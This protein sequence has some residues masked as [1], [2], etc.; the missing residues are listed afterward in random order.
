MRHTTRL[1]FFLSIFFMISYGFAQDI[2][3][4]EVYPQQAGNDNMEFIELYDG[5]VGN[6]PLD[7]YALVFY[8]SNGERSG[9][10]IS[11]DGYQTNANG[12]FV[13]GDSGVLNV[14]YVPGFGV[15]SDI[16]DINTGLALHAGDRGPDNSYSMIGSSNVVDAIYFGTDENEDTWPLRLMNCEEHKFR[17][18][19]NNLHGGRSPNLYSIQRSPNG[20][21]GARNSS[22]FMGYFP[23]PGEP[24][25]GWR[26]V[27]INEI[28]IHSG[29]PD[30]AKFIEIYDGGF[31]NTALDSFMVVLFNDSDVSYCVIDLLGRS[32]DDDGYF[33]IGSS[34]MTPAP[35][36]DLP[37]I[38]NGSDGRIGLYLGLYP[39]HFPDGTGWDDT[40]GG[41]ERDE[42]IWDYVSYVA[43]GIPETQSYQR[44]PN[45]A[46]ELTSLS[47]YNNAPPTPGSQNCP[48][49]ISGFVWLDRN[50]NGIQDVGESDIWHD[51]NSNVNYNIGELGTNG[52][53]VNLLNNTST[54]IA[55]MPT[56]G[57]GY[58]CFPDLPAAD[59]YIEVDLTTLG[60][61][62]FFSPQNQGD[63]DIDS[64]AN[65]AT[66]RTEV[67]A[68][69]GPTHIQD[70]YD[71]GF[72]QYA[73]VGDLVWDDNNGDG[74]RDGADAGHA[75][76]SVE[77]FHNS[78]SSAA[79]PVSTNSNGN[80][81]F[82]DLTPGEYYLHFTAPTGFSFTHP[83][84]YNDER[85]SE[86]YGNGDTRPFFLFSGQDDD[87]H[88]AGLNNNVFD[89]NDHS[90][91]T[92]ANGYY[93]IADITISTTRDYYV[94]F[95][96]PA[97]Y[98]FSPMNVGADTLDSDADPDPAANPGPDLGNSHV[99]TET[100]GMNDH[101]VDAG[102]YRKATIGNFVWNDMDVNGEYN[103]A[104][105]DTALAGVTVQL[106]QGGSPVE[107]PIV[108]DATG[109]YSFEVAP[110]TYQ[111]KFTPPAD[112][113]ITPVQGVGDNHN[114]ADAAD[115]LTAPMTVISGSVDTLIDAGMYKG[116]VVGDQVW[117]D[118]DGDGVQDSG[119]PGVGNVIVKIYSSVDDD[120]VA[121]DTTDA[122]GQYAFKGIPPGNYYLQFTLPVGYDAFTFPNLGGP[123]DDSDADSTGRTPAMA[124]TVGTVFD[125]LDAGL[126]RYGEIG[127]FVW[128]DLNANG[129]QETGEPGIDAVTVQLTGAGPDSLFGNGDDFSMVT[130]TT[131][132]TGHYIFQNL[133]P[134]AYHIEWLRP[135][136]AQYHYSVQSAGSL[137]LIDSDADAN[138][139]FYTTIVSG[140]IDTTLDAG[141][142]GLGE[143]G[144]IIWLDLDAD[145]LQETGEVGIT[146]VVTVGLYRIGTMDPLAATNT[147]NGG[148]GFQ[149]VVPGDYY[150]TF[151]VPNGYLLSPHNAG[152]DDTIDSD[153][154][155]ANMLNITRSDTFTIVS[156][157]IDPTI[158]GGIYQQTG[159]GDFV[160]DDLNANGVQDNGEPGI[161]S[162]EVRLIQTSNDSLI[163]STLT[164]VNGNFIIS[165]VTPG[166]YYL[167]FIRPATEYIFTYRDMVADS[168][169]SD[170]DSTG[171]TEDFTFLSGQDNLF[172]D[173]GFYRLA[174][175]G[176]FI[177]HDRDADGI[178]ESGE[179]GLGGINVTLYYAGL[180]H[181]FG[182]SDDADSTTNSLAGVYGFGD[183][184]PGRYYLDIDMGSYEISP[185]GQG[186]Q[187]SID[188]NLNP[189]TS[190][191]DIFT[192]ISHQNQNSM[193]AGGYL[194]T[195]LGDW[196]WLDMDGDG[197]QGVGELGLENVDIHLFG[198]GED[199][200]FGTSDDADESEDTNSSGF[201]S[202]DGMVP[203]LYYL[204]FDLPSSAYYVSPMNQAGDDIDSDV[205]PITMRTD[206]ITVYSDQPHN[207]MDMGLY[208]DG[209][210]GD[211][212]WE[213]Q[214]GDGVQDA[215]EPGLEGVYVHLFGAGLDDN[216]GTGDDIIRAD[217]TSSEGLYRFDN[218][219]PGRYRVEF[220]LLSGYEFSPQDQGDDQHDSD[221]DPATASTD[222]FTVVAGGSYPDWD[223]G[224]YRSGKVGDLVWED[225][226]GNGQQ[227]PGEPGIEGVTIE[228]ARSSDDSIVGSDQS[229]ANGFFEIGG[230][231]PGSYYLLLTPLAGYIP[232]EPD[233][234][235][236]DAIDNDVD[237]N[238]LESDIFDM[239]TNQIDTTR[240]A[241][242]YRPVSIGDR[243][244]NDTDPDGIQESGE[245]GLG[246][247]RVNLYGA[248]WNGIFH[249]DIDD[250]HLSATT[251]ASGSYLFN[252]LRPGEYYLEFVVSSGYTI[253]LQN[254]EDDG[255]LDSDADPETGIVDTL[256]FQSGTVD[257]SIDAGFF[258]FGSIGDL[259]YYDL[260][261][262]GV[263]NPSDRG[264]PNVTIDLHKDF[265]D[266]GIVDSGDPY[267]GSD[268]TQAAGSYLFE[269]LP[270][271]VYLVTI[272]DHNSV[273]PS[274][275][276]ILTDGS[277]P[278]RVSLSEGVD[279]LDADFGYQP[280]KEGSISGIIWN[281]YN[282]DCGSSDEYGIFQKMLQLYRD[283]DTVGVYQEGV[284]VYIA[285][286]LSD[287][288]GQY[289][290]QGLA[291]GDYFVRAILDESYS[292]TCS[293]NPRSVHLNL[294]QE[295]EH[296]NFGFQHLNTASIFG[297]V[298]NDANA[299]CQ[300]GVGEVGLV[301]VNVA[302]YKDSNQDGILDQTDEFL[303]L[304][305]TSNGNG[306]AGAYLFDALYAGY[307]LVQV[308]N[309]T[310]E[311]DGF[312]LVCETNPEPV[313]LLI[314]EERPDVHFYYQQRD[315]SINGV[316]WNDLDGNSFKDIDEPGIG[317]ISITLYRDINSNG[318]IDTGTD[319]M[320]GSLETDSGGN[321]DFTNLPAGDYLAWID[322]PPTG[323]VRT[324]DSN[325]LLISLIA[326]RI[327]T[328]A[329]FGYRQKDASINGV[330][331]NDLDGDS[332]KGGSELGMSGVTIS[333][334]QS[335]AE[336]AVDTTDVSGNYQFSDLFSGDH[337][338]TIT[339]QTNQLDG[340]AITTE[341]ETIPVSTTPG[342]Q[343]LGV[344]FGYQQ[345]DAV[346]SGRVWNDMDNNGTQDGDEIGIGNVTLSLYRGSN[347]TQD[348]ADTTNG[349]GYYQFSDLPFGNYRVQVTDDNG[350][351]TDFNLTNGLVNP[352]AT[353]V[354]A[355][356]HRIVNFGYRPENGV[357]R[358][359]VW[360]DLNGDGIRDPNESNLEGIQVD[361][362]LVGGAPVGSDNTASDGQYL[363]SNLAE[364]SYYLS[365][366]IS[367]PY[368]VSPRDQGS[369]DNMDSDAYENAQTPSF[370]LSAG[371]VI[372]SMDIGVYQT[373][374]V[375]DFVYEDMN[376]NGIQDPGEPGL[377]ELVV[378]LYKDNGD[379]IFI[380]ATLSQN[381]YYSFDG[382]D[383]GAYYLRFTPPNGYHTSPLDVGGDD[384]LD[385]DIDLGGQTETFV[386]ESGEV[387]AD[388]DAGM[389]RHSRINGW[390]W[391]DLNGD[392]LQDANE[393]GMENLQVRLFRMDDNSV[394][395]TTYSDATGVYRFLD[396]PPA[397]YYLTI[398]DV[399]NYHFT[400]QGA[401]DP[402]IDSDVNT[403]GVSE[404][405]MLLSDQNRQDIDAG[406]Y[407]YA[408]LGDFVWEDMNENG[409]QDGGEDEMPNV[410]VN[411]YRDGE[412]SPIQSAVT[413]GDGEYIFDNLIPGQFY[414]EILPPNGYSFTQKD[415]G[416]DDNIDSDASVNG[417][418]SPFP[419]N[420]GVTDMSWD[421]GMITGTSVGDLVWEDL[422]VN[423][424]QDPGE[425]GISGVMVHLYETPTTYLESDTTDSQGLYGFTSLSD[426]I[427]YLI[428]TQPDDYSFTMRD[429]GTDDTVDSDVDMT[430]RTNDFSLAPGQ[431]NSDIDAGFYQQATIGDFV[432]ED[433]NG[434]G[435]Q[436]ENE[437]DRG[438][439]NIKATLYPAQG[440][441]SLIT[442]TDTRG[443]YRF[444]DVNPGDYRL[445][446]ALLNTAS[447]DRFTMSGQGSDMNVD[448]DPDA[449]GLTSIFSLASGDS[450][451]S[452][453]AGLYR[454]A[455]VQGIVWLDEN[456]DGI[457]NPIEQERPNVSIKLLDHNGQ[458]I[459]STS[460]TGS[461]SFSDLSPAGY[462][463]QAMEVPGLSFSPSGA[464][465]K[466]DTLTGIVP[467]FELTSGQ[468]AQGFH[469]GF[470]PDED[471]DRIVDSQDNC[472]SDP[473]NDQA[474]A[475]GD[476]V[477]DVCDNCPNNINND[478]I[479]DDNDS[480]GDACDACL[481]FDDSVDGDN[482]QIPDGCDELPPFSGVLASTAI[483]PWH[484]DLTWGYN[485]NN[486]MGFIIERSLNPDDFSDAHS[487]QISANAFTYRDTVEPSTQYCYRVFAFNIA[488]NP[489]TYSNV[490]CATTPPTPIV[491]SEVTETVNLPIAATIQ[492]SAWGDMD[493]DGY[494]DLF[495]VSAENGNSLRLF[496]NQQGAGFA[497]VSDRLP[498]DIAGSCALWGDYDNDLDL[499][500]FIGS[501]THTSRIYENDGNGFFTETGDRSDFVD[502]VQSAAWADFDRDGDIDLYVGRRSGQ[503]NQLYRNDLGNL[504]PIQAGM[505]DSTGSSQSCVWGDFD[506]D[507]DPDLFVA[508]N[509]QP[510][511]LYVNMDGVFQDQAREIGVDDENN[512]T[513]GAAYADFDNDG[514][515][516]IF[517]ANNGQPNRLYVNTDGLFQDQASNLGVASANIA[518]QCPGWGD[519]DNDMDLDLFV[520][521]LNNE[522]D[523][524]FINQGT[525]FIDLAEDV[526]IDDISGTSSAAWAD[527]D[528][529]GFIDL[530]VGNLSSNRLYQNSGNQSG[531]LGLRLLGDGANG[532]AIGA[533][534]RLVADG[535]VQTREVSGGSGHHS[536]NSLTLM[537][538]LHSAPTVDSL[539]IYFRGPVEDVVV[540]T[541]I[542]ANQTLEISQPDLTPPAAIDDLQEISTNMNL[543]IIQWTA[544]GDNG[545]WGIA[546][547]YD[548]RWSLDPILD[549]NGDQTHWEEAHT[550][551]GEPAPLS[552]RVSQSDTLTG[553]PL[554]ETVYVAIRTIDEAG[555]SSLSNM[556]R[557]E[558][559]QQI[560]GTVYD[561]QDTP[562]PGI[563]I[564]AWDVFPDGSVISTS[565]T[566]SE[567]N[568][569]LT[570]LT[571][572]HVYQIRAHSQAPYDHYPAILQGITSPSYDVRI[573]LSA[574]PS[575]M[576]TDYFA[577]FNCQGGTTLNDYPVLDGDVIVAVDGQGTV[578]GRAFLV[579]TGG[580]QMFVYGDIPGTTDK[581]GAI[582]G[583]TLTFRV[584]D[585]L[586]D[587]ISGDP[588][589]HSQTVTELC[590]AAPGQ[591]IQ[592]TVPLN[593]CENGSGWNLISWNVNPLNDSTSDVFANILDKV[594][595]VLGYDNGALSFRPDLP[596]QFN[597]LQTVD[598]YHGYWVKVT[599]SCALSVIGAPVDPAT[600]LPLRIGWNF[601]SYTPT[602]PSSVT[603][604]LE[605][606]IDN[607]QIAISY[608]GFD[609]Q[610]PARIF[611]PLLPPSFSNFQVI[612]PTMGLWVRMTAPDTLVYPQPIPF[613]AA[614]SQLSASI[615]SSTELENLGERG[616]A[617]TNQWIMIYSRDAQI[618]DD[619]LP[620]GTLITA[621][622][623]QGQVCGATLVKKAGQ[624]GLMAIYG[625]DPGTTEP[626]NVVPGES[627]LLRFTHHELGFDLVMEE[628][629]IWTQFGDIQEAQVR[630]SPD[631]TDAVPNEFNLSQNSPNPF[632][633]E[634]FISFDLPT[635]AKTTLKVYN[636]TGQLVRTLIKDQAYE[637]GYYS[638]IWDGRNDRGSQASSGVYFYQ[639][640]AKGQDGKR[641]EATRRM[642]L[643]R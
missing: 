117:E 509:G 175:V 272:T 8:F 501:D 197:V 90:V 554:H 1:F 607:M 304:I 17:N 128:D 317:Q 395:G 375:G 150:L 229:D 386:L 532:S 243:V 40:G 516:D 290:F 451:S 506:N 571:E 405:F 496:H 422:N 191:T 593:R 624:F 518:S 592:V 198:A 596:P 91:Y 170:A 57:G 248:G 102:M 88:D 161:N 285:N 195:S 577:R 93:S 252:D 69:T 27:R 514:D 371:Q 37:N 12:Y 437:L 547:H 559:P 268:T 393:S 493:N 148:Y 487:I 154:N 156:N 588:I 76:V 61:D 263:Q 495:L 472:P 434:N 86:A 149:N 210:V 343:L 237:S 392:G 265:N 447:A 542:E 241:G 608:D 50:A 319:L 280:L 235:N 459:D 346:I 330:V 83:Y 485:S 245:P 133:I 62:Y 326:G 9:N 448:S 100:A 625:D 530:H 336:I 383:P 389:F 512:N 328:G 443:M 313:R 545:N 209:F 388:I 98:H 199:Q 590:L 348:D 274:S 454:Y 309:I 42:F 438:I 440:G 28:D 139:I 334:Y 19:T 121:V 6:T 258:L 13:V 497:D 300:L 217:T 4:N 373:A 305:S 226:N 299:D 78:G 63:D 247:I 231:Q 82:P 87:R 369:D 570:N 143:I 563:A 97:G 528:R 379:G 167:R 546:S 138:G 585:L 641:F 194:E 292:L 60:A 246:G 531:Y 368:H 230:V 207:D 352:Q 583:E 183:L 461:Y 351:L 225:M 296:V 115:S 72:Y 632:N 550:V 503:P 492:A 162:V 340:F 439:P 525:H 159:I 603:Y 380:E 202:F 99:I 339:D 238:T 574:T 10:F 358:G 136:P 381:G 51:S 581:E 582:D 81:N 638:T 579:N 623:E 239:V 484:I 184:H 158:D 65:T 59:Y 435:V 75:G 140:E 126:I 106:Y 218:M 586:A 323:F 56:T 233:L 633:P 204:E 256:L 68:L 549:P 306:D 365:F 536:Q 104:G 504:V 264:V 316:V 565:F 221:P 3:I 524:L 122:G 112:F 616:V 172:M 400:T 499:D 22:S 23:T 174:Q 462:F 507:G 534:V 203:G 327:E 630:I 96:L 131:D 366:H 465:S 45:G 642:A 430:G 270:D 566:D 107:V 315:A 179:P 228:L 558:P 276:Y 332:F 153:F 551:T 480:V 177:W 560:S 234:G 14:G 598:P 147:V 67:I 297:L 599:E 347:P 25:F 453:D 382:M 2:V 186:S 35:D 458:Q 173:A 163:D 378:S 146:E 619:P 205:D 517:V 311:L 390:A 325:P 92:D 277:N 491:F 350:V 52:V 320:V 110:G 168:L 584:N 410:T 481:G 553:V 337:L 144:D 103:P 587:P 192:L 275:D 541:D 357:I 391:I 240:D 476:E 356:Q 367:T 489:G 295:L 421:A 105:G 39:E 279:Y 123:N 214:N 555:N 196:V 482:D 631:E 180:D 597:S 48:G 250:I 43:S 640:K 424:I 288:L 58:Y 475:D 169:D 344:D 293:T 463:L 255:E 470:Y 611:H 535:E 286:Q 262:N 79:G 420:S 508:N 322:Q 605:S 333:L 26:K 604:A 200:I 556:I 341:Y 129:L 427:Y 271:S 118:V 353:N 415:Q 488:F 201:Y 182:T 595:V 537:F 406:L 301:S 431:S 283:V 18:I 124:F 575:I 130:E 423:G 193:D 502:A 412:P 617:K 314:N 564:Q 426:E 376:A 160:W 120:S 46:G 145:G 108:T 568:F 471:R 54:Q 294:N 469:I 74:D 213:D 324:S 614:E 613:I 557:H 634:T 417:R 452:R 298:W 181:T 425:S 220:D 602:Q 441:D 576:P 176:D 212:V 260:N 606:I 377:T 527:F 552:S 457:L 85:D 11:L 119:E 460:V 113:R 455:T 464:D 543:M 49:C 384:T 621:E 569:Q 433:M 44:C 360:H 342:Q 473:N 622:D 494:D 374:V 38:P 538:G 165:D 89:G 142:Y 477:G 251:L 539:Y 261:G 404:N 591:T 626:E 408:A 15:N 254:Q 385:S 370:D 278:Q 349:D 273:L 164:D 70:S 486:E 224:M 152:A 436:D 219:V 55:T 211:F 589:W 505:T 561:E 127:N 387:R 303:D 242:L 522:P 643:L 291:E 402:P 77:L 456:A 444:D 515:L 428:F 618:Q 639:L 73:S 500:L 521:N 548:I 318:Q 31:G 394:I 259:V 529:D 266:N 171:R 414:L 540:M 34:G 187:E 236:N 629:L 474:N 36:I 222:T 445:R 53:T 284:D 354:V 533:W 573:T 84:W 101:T 282:T 513:R 609:C 345:R 269:K 409:L 185:M 215:M 520:G 429:S 302:L 572:G 132:S 232:T 399:G 7:G 396:I 478:Q 116:W 361:L 141:M 30:N 620:V 419:L 627:F 362:L 307:Y 206:T 615:S 490:S 398:S 446:F 432:W 636:M 267:M 137:P 526:Q 338:V 635:R 363:F 151:S 24:N 244:W 329:D 208:M 562:L 403:Q 21:G 312:D 467:L 41:I 600:P 16:G 372:Q 580:Y 413:N 253:T 71:A 20:Y 155:P 449:A 94:N 321:Y 397:T 135:D 111:V 510:N 166:E 335:G 416:T 601:I 411:L 216:F 355:G 281:D 29:S 523:Q 64:D 114:H 190:T 612:E 442:L 5:G 610:D 157:Q 364:G 287:S 188:N 223:A 189:A 418:T 511:R 519:V 359:Q 66:G 498:Q 33:L 407:Q 289:L 544:V 468:S 80:F 479:D 32:T 310:G 134:S 567:G 178:Q 637:A 483:S 308:M 466:A 125:S 450:D 257:S 594:T 109:A 47:T 331:W 578:V 95:D 628:P 227:D 249:D 401:G